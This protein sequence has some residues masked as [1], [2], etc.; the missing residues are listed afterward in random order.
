[1]ELQ[2]VELMEHVLVL[3]GETYIEEGPDYWYRLDDLRRMAAEG[4]RLFFN[5]EEQWE[6]WVLLGGSGLDV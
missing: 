5:S 2:P 6:T 1:M 4:C 3:N